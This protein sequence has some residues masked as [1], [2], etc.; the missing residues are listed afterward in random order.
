MNDCY[1]SDPLDEFLQH[2]P[3][4]PANLDHK[5]SLFRRTAQTLPR[6]RRLPL[7]SLSLAAGILLGVL[8]SYA[9]FH[10][11][12]PRPP[13]PDHARRDT[14]TPRSPEKQAAQPQRPTA[15]DSPQPGELEWRAFDA[16]TDQERR[17]L[18]YQAGDLYLAV[19]HDVEAALRCYEQ[20]L[21]YSNTRE[22]EFD[23][24]DNWL[25]MA[26]KTDRRKDY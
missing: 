21:T 18:Y 19:S 12:G 11:A 5:E 4:L 8:L 3:E 6:P 20:A 25:V 9:L 7:L 14:G 1:S 26:L 16:T 17:R 15:L 2:P 10:G 22:L 24:N 13:E 23:P